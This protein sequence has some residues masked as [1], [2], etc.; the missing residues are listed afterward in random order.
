MRTVKN[1]LVFFAALIVAALPARAATP[2]IG[3]Q[4]FQDTNARIDDLFQYRNN[5]PKPPGPQDNP[6]RPVDAA[7]AV[8][9]TVID[10]AGNSVAAPVIKESPDESLLRQAYT[11]IT[12]GGLLQV[13]G[14]PMVVINKATYKEGGLLIVRVQGND[15]YL[16]IVQLTNDSITLGL[17]DAR[18]RLNF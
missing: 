15:V 14:R 10:S 11:R 7:A 13:G 3:A 9:N 16:R 17:K 18:L 12:F 6:F 8:Q 1:A 5:P 2:V 4:L